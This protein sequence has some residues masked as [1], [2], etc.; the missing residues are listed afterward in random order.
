MTVSTTTINRIKRVI[1]EIAA[2]AVNST[3]PGP[4][5]M[6]H[7]HVISPGEKLPVPPGQRFAPQAAYDVCSTPSGK[8]H[9]VYGKNPATDYGRGDMR[10]ITTCEPVRM[11]KL[12]EDV[13]ALL[14]EREDITSLAGR[15]DDVINN[16]MAGSDDPRAKALGDAVEDYLSSAP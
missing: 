10:H 3:S 1:G 4:W 15:L 9:T 16:T 12:T 13:Q 14:D 6:S 11:R 7:G 5:Y 2:N 8:D